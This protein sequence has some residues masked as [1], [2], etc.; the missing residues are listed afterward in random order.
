MLAALAACL[1]AAAPLAAASAAPAGSAPVGVL[2][3]KPFAREAASFERTIHHH[4]IGEKTIG[5][6]TAHEA[7]FPAASAASVQRH[8]IVDDVAPA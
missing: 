5:R 7:P 1:L 4:A 2:Q 8:H 3:D 6:A